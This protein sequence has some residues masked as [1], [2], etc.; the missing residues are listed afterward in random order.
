M[1]FKDGY[2]DFIPYRGDTGYN[3]LVRTCQIEN[4]TDNSEVMTPSDGW[5]RKNKIRIQSRIC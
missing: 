3:V 1:C 5:I 2:R 4:R